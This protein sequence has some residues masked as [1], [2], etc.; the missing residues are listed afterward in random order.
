[1]PKKSTSAGTRIDLGTDDLVALVETSRELAGDVHLPRLLRRIL[2]QATRLTDS[3]DASVLLLDESRS[4]L[5]F[6]DA[7]GAFAPKL[8]EQWGRNGTQG[9]PL[10]GSKAGQVF[11]SMTSVIVDAIPDDP[12]HFKGTDRAT[13]AVTQSMVCVPLVVP[14][15]ASG[16]PRALGVIQLLNKRSGN[17]NLRDRTLLE[18]FADQAAV[19]IDNARL[20]SDLYAS[21][22]LYVGEDDPTDPRDLLTRPAWNEV[23]SVLIA[24]MRGFTQLCQVIGRPER[25][26]A[27]LNQFLGMLVDAVIAHRGVVNKFLGDG[28]LAFF[29]GRDSGRAAVGCAFTM[30]RLFDAMKQAWDRESNVKLRFLDLGIGISTEDVILGAVGGERVWDFTAIGT[31]VNLAAHLMENARDGRR[32]YVDKVT[33]HAARPIV[34]RFEGPEEFELRK[35]GQTVAHPYERYLLHETSEVAPAAPSP[36]PAGVRL[37]ISYS[38][39]DKAWRDLLRTHLEPYVTSGSIQVWDDKSMEAGTEWK[40]AIDEA[41]DKAAAA[42]FLVS[43][44]LLASGFV[45]KEE[46]TP[47]VKRARAKE[48]KL[49]WLPVSASSYEETEFATL[50]A[51]LNPA[52]PLD[53][54]TE[55]QQHERL[56]ELCKIIKSSL[57]THAG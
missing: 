39:R 30:L 48:V 34:Q 27:L 35:P 15:H 53:Q 18:R 1:M 4:C 2:S 8:L 21:K 19:A 46:L 37:F 50:Q 32:L 56:V 38:H 29:R 7:L 3:P 24:D 36:A 5:Y 16:Q 45:R 41:I 25:T 44:N 22:G 23:L 20:V 55:A 9:V 54:L 10:I 52:R 40:K 33:F 47:L 43:P 17:Y 49:F 13:T 57:A 12:N 31:G 28:L 11:T 6:A 42:L 14:N 51:A 26:Q